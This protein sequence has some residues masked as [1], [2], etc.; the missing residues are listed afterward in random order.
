M[1]VEGDVLHHDQTVSHSNTS[2]DEVDGVAPHVPVH[3][4]H[5]VDNVEGGA[6]DTD[7][8]SQVAMDRQVGSL[9]KIRYG[10]V[11]PYLWCGGTQLQLT[12]GQVQAGQVDAGQQGQVRG[13]DQVGELEYYKARFNFIVSNSFDF[14]SVIRSSECQIRELFCQNPL[15]LAD[16]TQLQLVEV[17]V[18]FVFPRKE[19]RR[20]EGITLT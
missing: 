20:K 13:A 5:H 18:D 7:S 11:E 15:Q 3:E 4:H 16:P 9:Q 6:Q 1:D 14:T 12:E 8:H 19:G 10:A 2:E 17:G